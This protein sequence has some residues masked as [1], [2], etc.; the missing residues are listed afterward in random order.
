MESANNSKMPKSLE[1]LLTVTAPP[2]SGKTS[3]VEPSSLLAKLDSFLPKMKQANLKL[4]RE[5]HNQDLLIR[6]KDDNNNTERNEQGNENESEDDELVVNM[7]VYL[8]NAL[9]K[10]VPSA[11][12][13]NDNTA[14]CDEPQEKGKPL[15]QVV[16]S[17]D[18]V[19]D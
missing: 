2:L 3:C 18:N 19:E 15:I 11:D 16:E 6:V 12:N 14:N 4:D 17:S 9:G 13:S 1:R 8:D 7:D 5:Q 10:L